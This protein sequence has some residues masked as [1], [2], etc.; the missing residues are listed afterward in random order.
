MVRVS[1]RVRVLGL[2]PVLS[3]FHLLRGAFSDFPRG[4][5]SLSDSPWYLALDASTT[6]SRCTT[7]QR[8]SSRARVRGYHPL[9]PRI[10]A[11]S[12][13][14]ATTPRGLPVGLLPVRSPLLGKSTFVSSPGLIDM[15]K[16]GPS[17]RPSGALEARP[18]PAAC[19][20][21]SRS[22]SRGEPIGPVQ[23][24]VLFSSS[25]GPQQAPQ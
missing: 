25:R 17:S 5:C 22:S 12:S 4:T 19:R 6:R 2:P 21:R 16:S 14:V 1:I 24:D 8:Y 11:R 15:L 10:P 7:K 20:V 23:E 3:L 9:W 18:L 13:R